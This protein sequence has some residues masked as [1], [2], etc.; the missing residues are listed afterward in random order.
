MAAAP[1][2]RPVLCPR[3]SWLAQ[4]LNRKPPLESHQLDVEIAGASC[5]QAMR[6]TENLVERASG[7]S[8]PTPSG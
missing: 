1:R 8:R 5:E 4:R 6:L 3:I 2:S 7:R